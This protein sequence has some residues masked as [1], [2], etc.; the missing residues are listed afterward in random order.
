MTAHQDRFRHL[1]VTGLMNLHAV[2]K[3]AL[4]I[5]TPQAARLEHYPEVA[6]RLRLYIDETHAQIA[7]LDELLAGLIPVA[8]S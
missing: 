3:Q 8:R 5:I 4:S 2:E 6:D 1:F 7:R